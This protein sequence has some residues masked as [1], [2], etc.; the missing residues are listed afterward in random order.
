MLCFTYPHAFVVGCQEW[1]GVQVWDLVR[2][3]LVR[4]VEQGGMP[5][6]NIHCNGRF[7]TICELNMTR[8]GKK[9]AKP[10][11]KVFDTLEL[12]DSKIESKDLWTKC[13]SYSPGHYFEQINAVSN[14]TSLI[15]HHAST[16]S[17]LNFWKDR[18]ISSREFVPEDN[19]SDDDNAVT[20]THQTE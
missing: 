4:H 12:V 13:V 6:H 18:I 19:E 20:Q 2:C 15:V 9:D 3:E 7:I 14:K 10:L 11:V 8:R 5:F 16:I 17:V 1:S